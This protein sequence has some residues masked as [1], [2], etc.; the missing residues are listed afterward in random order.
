MPEVGDMAPDFE[1]KS[2]LEKDKKVRLS[3]FRGKQN[4]LLAF[5]P[6]AFSPVCSHQLPE[7]QQHLGEFAAL[8]T[9]VLGISVDSHYSNEAFAK[10]L[11][12][13]FPLLSDFS[14]EVSHAYGVFVPEK[15]YSGRALFLIDREGRLIYRDLSPK[16]S[17]IPSPEKVLAALRAQK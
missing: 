4:V 12:L 11:G 15:R 2:N 8:D 17:Q 14:H 13:D 5:F 16:T 9:A 1:L 6:L 10:Q 3:D 7:L